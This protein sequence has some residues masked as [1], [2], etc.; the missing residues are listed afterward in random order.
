MTSRSALLSFQLL[1][2]AALI[3]LGTGA[4]GVAE[5]HPVEQARAPVGIIATGDMADRL[6]LVAAADGRLMSTGGWLGVVYATSDDPGFAARLYKA[7]AVLVF[8]A[9]RAIGCD[10]LKSPARTS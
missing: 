1:P 3:L 8:R 5:L 6:R 9:D 10:D 7:G 4:L 2:A